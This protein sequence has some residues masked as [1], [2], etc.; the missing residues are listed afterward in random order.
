MYK[1]K[2]RIVSTDVVIVR[3]NKVLMQK[4]SFG[5]FKGYWHLVC[6]KVEAGETIIHA[7]IREVKEETSLDV[8]RIQMLG[9]YDGKERDPEQNCVAIGFL[10]ETNDAEPRLSREA[11]EMKFFPFDKLPKRIAFDDRLI[12]E[13]AKKRMKL[14]SQTK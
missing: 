7:A 5:M 12:I 6:G 10:C 3:D 4:R 1:G 8:K 11:T 9:I 13:D 2:Y 14:L